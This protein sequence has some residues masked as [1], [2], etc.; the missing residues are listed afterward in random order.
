MK[1]AKLVLVRC[2]VLLRCLYGSH[3]ISESKWESHG[4][5]VS[6]AQTHAAGVWQ[7]WHGERSSV[8]VRDEFDFL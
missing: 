8:E 6:R 4:I 1:A 3:T 5:G 2:I 7:A